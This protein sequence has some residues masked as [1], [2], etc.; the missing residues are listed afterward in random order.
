MNRT[1]SLILVLSLAVLTILGCG[2]SN[3]VGVG[4]NTAPVTLTMTDAPPAG[5]TVLSF[6][7]TVTSASLNP[8]AIQ[9]V[10]SPLKI[11]VTKLEADSA[12]LSTLSVPTGT[13][14]SVSAT[15]SNPEITFLNQSG[16]TLAGCANN[17]ICEIQ[18]ANSGTTT[19]SGAPFPLT[20]T[21]GAP[22]ALRLDLNVANII[23]PAL[24]VDFTAANSIVVT[25]LAA[26]VSGDLDRMDDLIGIVQ[27]LDATNHKFTLHTRQGDFTITTDGNTEFE[28]PGCTAANFNCLQAGQV[29]DVDAKLIPGGVIVARRI[30]MDDNAEDDEAEGVIS[31]IDDATHFEMV[32][33][34]H[35][36][37][38]T[39][40]SLGNPVIVTLNSASFQVKADGLTIPGNLQNTFQAATDTAQL[41]P[42]QVVQIRITSF[43]AGPPRAVTTNRVRLRMTQFTGSVTS[44]ASPNF[45]LGSLPALFTNAGISSVLVVTSNR[46][47][48]DGVSGVNALVN[49]NTVSTRGL[50]F[51]DGVNPP[52]MIA[53]KVR[54]R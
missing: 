8:G 44:T 40:V 47:D 35:L 9:L 29:V 54:K 26:N 16:A 24:G 17:A 33:L 12:F 49:G 20:I 39:S 4:V 41:L 37:S 51:K 10:A 48:F 34:D 50:L 21:M 30:E 42:G 18:L 31:K 14:T 36:P 25:Q 27:N 1:R 11:E 5:V 52:Q 13:Y 46:T 23:T 32:I 53:K 7:V 22:S 3:Q 43:T 2:G 45:T 15:F 19:Y 6:E 38:S 28:I